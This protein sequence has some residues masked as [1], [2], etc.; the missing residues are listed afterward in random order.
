VI[1]GFLFDAIK[2]RR[3][4]RGVKLLEEGALP[5]HKAGSHRR[6]FLRDLLVYR[7]RRDVARKAALDRIAKEAF[8][9]GLYE[10]TGIPE[11]GE[12]E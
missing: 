7:K 3:Y 9:S 11:G 4:R 1:A 8:E 10:H 12:D 2:A 6:I 5:F